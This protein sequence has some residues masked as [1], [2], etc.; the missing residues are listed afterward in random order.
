V[1]VPLRDEPAWR[2]QIV[3]LRLAPF[4]VDGADAGGM[5]TVGPIVLRGSL[6]V[7]RY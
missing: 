1:V 6:A 2:G 5:A 7:P 4:G 3:S